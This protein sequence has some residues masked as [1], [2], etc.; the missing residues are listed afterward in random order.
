MLKKF[1]ALVFGNMIIISAIAQTGSISGILVDKTDN[2]PVSS[3]TVSLLLQADSSMVKTV[4]SDNSGHFGFENVPNDNFIVQITAIN[5]QEYLSFFTIKN[6]QK[7]LGTIGLDRQGQDLS[8]VTVVSKVSPVVQKGDTAQFSA[9]QYKVNPDATTEDLIKKMPGISVAK[10]GTVTAQGETV[11][12][13]TID[14]KDFFGDDVS[15]ALKNL[16]SEV[17]DKIQVYD[18][19]SDQA[20]LTGFDDGNGVKAINIVTK[21]GIKNGQFGRIYAGAGTEGTYSGGGNVSF[22][23]GDRRV[24]IVGNFNNI[25]QQNFGSQDLLGVTS[26]GGGGRGGR[27]G[28]RFGGENFSVG[29][30]N[31]ISK[32]N[33]FGINYNDQWGKKITASGSYF[34]NTSTNN[35][36]SVVNTQTLLTNGKNLYTNQQSNSQA[37]NNNNRIN[38]RIEYKIDSSNS[39]FIIPSINF[40]SNNSSALSNYQS[41]YGAGDSTSTSLNNNSSDRNGFNIRNNILFRHSFAKRGR[42]LIFGFNTTFTRND[43]TGIND[44]QYRFFDNGIITDSTQN[45]YSDNN[46]NGHTIGGSIAYTEPIGKKAQLQISYNPSVQKNNADQ[47]TFNYDGAK[48]SDFDTAF[49]NRFENTI[50]TN[51]AGLSYRYNPSRDEHFGIGVNFQNSKLESVRT[52]PTNS[53]VHQSFSDIL[54][55]LMWRKKFTAKSSIR[56]YY[57]ASTNFPSINQLQDVVNQSNP[58]AISSG[59]PNL[60][61]SS[62]NFLATRYVYTNSKTGQSFFANLFL[63]SADNYISNA[64][65]I[66]NQDSTIQ[67]GIVLKQNSQLTKPINLNGYQSLSSFFTYS[68]PVKFIKTN[69]N[70]NTGFSYSKLPGQAN[71]INTTTKNY[72]Y[73]TGVVFASN[74]SEFVDFNLSYNASF[75]NAKTTVSNAT[76]TNYVNQSA[77]L[78]LNLLDK[79]G[80]FVQNDIS[81]QSYSGLSSGLNQSFWLWNAAIGKKILKNHAGELKLS[82]F[83]LLKQNQSITRTVSANTIEDS[84]SKVLQQY[85]M[86]TFTYNLKNFGVASKTATH[87]NWKGRGGFHSPGF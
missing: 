74:I 2:K 6:N 47:Q 83:D 8:T 84:Q 5:F 49:S 34:F 46:T 69:I 77:G 17:V 18:R 23:K 70:L 9:S 29:Q 10:D 75:N 82:V 28:G 1:L 54:P 22:F 62:R 26:S 63:Q 58:L 44:G 20:Q 13:I 41:F 27:G 55:N 14:G 65:F 42:T 12:K 68:V 86:L 66:A 48:Y 57:R 76:N 73:N 25:N 53:T 35:N 51:N 32:T 37:V 79:K 19:L 60:K 85:F 52:F 59:N 24:S 64:I 67:Q 56:V 87:G 61:Q 15:A 31:G 39:I 80:W 81:N 3:A 7:N 16:P 43:G 4:L 45:Q 40:Q 71:Y 36:Q 11:K 72:V 33:A 38:F 30:S 78:Q 21:S 50:T